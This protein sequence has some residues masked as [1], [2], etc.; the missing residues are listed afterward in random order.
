[1]KKALIIATLLFASCGPSH[2]HQYQ[3][4]DLVSALHI[5]TRHDIPSDWQRTT[6]NAC[7]FWDAHQDWDTGTTA[8]MLSSRELEVEWVDKIERCDGPAP[9]GYRFTG[10]AHMQ[11]SRFTIRLVA[12]NDDINTV[13]YHEIGHV[14]LWLSENHGDHHAIIRPLGL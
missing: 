13:I 7:E 2:L 12:D 4:G 14:V 3:C 8:F 5:R 9:D 11:G 6:S 10:C 1:M